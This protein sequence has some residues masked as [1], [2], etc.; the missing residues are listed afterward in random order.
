MDEDVIMRRN[1]S[2]P[3]EAIV[4]LQVPNGWH[5]S[6]ASQKVAFDKAGDEKTAHFEVE[7]AALSEI[8]TQISAEL[9]YK[10]KKYDE[11]FSEVGRTDIATFYYYQ[12]SIQKISVVKVALPAN[13]KVGYL[14]GAGDDILPSLQQLGVDAHLL[15]SDELAHG[16][17]N[18]YGTIILGILAYDPRHNDHKFNQPLLNFLTQHV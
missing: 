6:P 17:L 1:R 18:H 14:E 2:T 12:P 5:V 9:E 11:G 16:D 4:E 15:S 8:R 7:P 13:L 10:G 3:A